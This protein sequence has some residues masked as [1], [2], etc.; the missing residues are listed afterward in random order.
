MAQSK[1]KQEPGFFW[2]GVLILVPVAIM[3]VLAAAAVIKD[4]VAAEQEMRQKAESLLEQINRDFGGQ[5]DKHRIDYEIVRDSEAARLENQLFPPGDTFRSSDNFNLQMEQGHV[6]PLNAFVTQQGVWF[7][8]AFNADGSMRPRWISNLHN[9]MRPGNEPPTP[10]SWRAELTPE[11]ALAW[12]NLC[13]VLTGSN[14][15]AVVKE[16]GKQF[17]ENQT[18]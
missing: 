13:R 17:K 8:P 10:P 2:Q 3:G 12:Q 14:N 9:S 6:E 7:C 15:L 18:H 11:Q 5:F 1:S 4:R 16:A